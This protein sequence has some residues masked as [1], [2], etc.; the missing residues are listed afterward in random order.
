SLK[1]LAYELQLA[2]TDDAVK[3]FNGRYAEAQKIYQDLQ[4]ILSGDSQKL[5]ETLWKYTTQYASLNQDYIRAWGELKKAENAV[6]TGGD[7][8]SAV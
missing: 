1:N 2:G 8:S 6:K 4:P 3:A 7:K 5:T